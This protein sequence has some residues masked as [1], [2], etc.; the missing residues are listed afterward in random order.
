MWLTFTWAKPAAFRHAGLAVPEQVTNADLE[1]LT[2]L[3]RSTAAERL[4]V[5]GDLI[6]AATGQSD[7]TVEAFRLWREQHEQLA[8]D[9]VLGIM[10]ARSV[11]GRRPGA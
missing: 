3:L 9:L 1:L 2:E 8:I 10:I 6:H 11:P 5:L 4:V 7:S